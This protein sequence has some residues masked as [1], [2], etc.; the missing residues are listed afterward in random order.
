[1][2]GVLMG[3]GEEHSRGS[4]SAPRFLFCWLGKRIK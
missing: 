1:M 2:L 3:M 4:P